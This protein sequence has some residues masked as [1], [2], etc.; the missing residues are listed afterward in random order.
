MSG[1][2]PSALGGMCVCM[3]QI[4]KAYPENV[5]HTH[6]M[7]VYHPPPSVVCVCVCVCTCSYEYLRMAFS[8]LRGQLMHLTG[9]DPLMD[10]PLGGIPIKVNV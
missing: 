2:Q 3:L 1:A 5:Y 7:Y 4:M 6:Y 9:S 8:E 10:H